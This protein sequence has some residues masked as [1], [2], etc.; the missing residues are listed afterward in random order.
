PIF[1]RGKT[2]ESTQAQT[3]RWTELA[4]GPAKTCLHGV[5][6]SPKASSKVA[7]FDLDGCVIE[8]SIGKKKVKDAPPNFQW[9]RAIVPEKLKELH[10]EG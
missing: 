10:E 5:N 6:Q 3:F 8:S 1:T 9:W 4:L 7:A 2:A